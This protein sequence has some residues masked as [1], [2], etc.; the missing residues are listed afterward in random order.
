M[1]DS[2]VRERMPRRAGH[3]RHGSSAS[4]EPRPSAEFRNGLIAAGLTVDAYDQKS[5]RKSFPGLS[6]RTDHVFVFI[7]FDCVLLTT[8]LLCYRA[9][10]SENKR[11]GARSVCSEDDVG[12]R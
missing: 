11:F 2:G 4:S 3:P 6:T 8:A 9:H 7:A 12:F 10:P 5:T 1:P